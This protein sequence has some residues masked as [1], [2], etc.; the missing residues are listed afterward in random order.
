MTWL[1]HAG[2]DV[3]VPLF[4]NSDVDLI[5]D[6]GDRAER[7]QVKTSTRWDKAASQ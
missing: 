1:T 6:F 4:T 5:A 3:Y 2:A 7:V